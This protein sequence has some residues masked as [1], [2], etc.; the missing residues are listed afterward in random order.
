MATAD[1]TAL[2]LMLDD[3][4]GSEILIE[5]PWQ[6]AGLRK[7]SRKHTYINLT[8]LNPTFI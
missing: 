6:T 4:G 5:E 1:D 8:P 3:K 7:T 2:C